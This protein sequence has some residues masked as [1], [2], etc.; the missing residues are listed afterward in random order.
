MAASSSS[1]PDRGTSGHS[2]ISAIE[3]A[4]RRLSRAIIALTL[5]KFIE[6]ASVVSCDDG[7]RAWRRAQCDA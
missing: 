3:P 6:K 1:P 7:A 2:R 4:A 5:G